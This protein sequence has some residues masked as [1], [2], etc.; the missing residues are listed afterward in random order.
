MDKKI[1]HPV[2]SILKIIKYPHDSVRFLIEDNESVDE[3]KEIIEEALKD[4]RIKERIHSYEF[5]LYDKGDLALGQRVLIL[6]M[7]LKG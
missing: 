1:K 5:S 4:D 7:N 3:Y 6:K 2:L